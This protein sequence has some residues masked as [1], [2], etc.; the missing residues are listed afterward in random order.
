MDKKPQIFIK[1]T[2]ANTVLEDYASLLDLAK[3]RQHFTF[4][5]KIILKL[6]LSWSKYFP[7]CSSPPWQVEGILKKMRGD[8]FIGDNLYTAENRTVVTDIAKGLKGNKWEPIIAKYDANFVPLTEVEFTPFKAEKPLHVLDSKVFPTGFSIP[9]FYIGKKIIHL[10][11]FKT[12]GHTGS[13]GGE[14]NEHNPESNGG[15]TC[16]MKNAF[17][18][19]LTKRRHFSHQFMSEVL[20]DLLI[21]Q[22]QIHPDIF[23]VVDGTVAGDGAGPRCMIPRIKNTLM[24]G[25]D[26]VAVD[27]MAAK[28]MGFDP[29]KLPA[30]KIAHDEGL[31]CGDVDQIEIIGDDVSQENWNF[32]VERSIVIWGDQQVR[33]GKLRF[34]EPLMHTWLFNVGPVMLSKVYHDYWW[35]NTT[36][37]KRIKEYN[38]T[39]WG[40]LFKTYPDKLENGQSVRFAYP[41]E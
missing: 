10:P 15:I 30:I 6:N 5:E 36:G 35:Y 34:L 25:Y 7:A 3:Y 2:T 21:I 9:N 33:K 17:G 24:A 14:F 39:E 32:H 27:A 28:I 12:H 1:K 22:Q 31:G 20:V 4:D 41:N 19:L 16:A 26:Q 13:E 8:G 18:G 23:A 37:R 29:M 40:Q 38:K 11:T